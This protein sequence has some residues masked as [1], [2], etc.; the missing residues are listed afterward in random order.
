MIMPA[1]WFWGMMGIVGTDF[2]F[3]YWG[4]LAGIGVMLGSILV[5]WLAFF[6]CIFC[7][8]FVPSISLAW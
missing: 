8:N 1:S 4:V 5:F 2:A 7:M 6:A 3:E